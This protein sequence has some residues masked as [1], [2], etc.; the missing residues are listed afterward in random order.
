MRKN[1]L[2]IFFTALSAFGHPHLFITAGI[3]PV[4]ENGY[5]TGIEI[6]WKWGDWWSADVISNCDYD[7]DGAFNDIE[8]DAVYSDYFSNVK[9]FNF[10]MKLFVNGKTI[11]PDIVDEFAAE[12]DADKK[13][14]YRF[15]VPCLVRIEN[16]IKVN[17]L[18]SDQT[19]YVA[20]SRRIEKTGNF[21]E[22]LKEF[23]RECIFLSVNS[24]A[25]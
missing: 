12:I 17:V 23:K 7:G 21:R 20:F 24:A 3:G 15:I 1:I 8:T 13:V 18:F 16:E 19:N 11:K 22:N 25:A 2:I 10:F 5:L 4:V 9:D 6:Q 14:T